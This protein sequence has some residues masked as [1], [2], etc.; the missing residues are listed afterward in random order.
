MK[1]S[2]RWITPKA[3]EEVAYMA[4]VSN[5]KAK[6]GDPAQKLIQFLLDNKHFSPFEMVCMCLDIETTRDVSRQMLRHDFRFQEFSQRYQVASEEPEMVPQARL[7]DEK[8]RQNSIPTTD[9][10]ITKRWMAIQNATWDF[11]WASYMV[12]LKLGI[13]KELARKLLPEG[14][15]RTHLYMQGTI[16]NWIFYIA[17]R[18]KPDT[19][20]EHRDVAEE[21]RRVFKMECPDIYA[22]AV[23]AGLIEEH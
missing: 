6:P 18:T 23:K 2:L 7:Q 14:L 22:A 5:P 11:C 17:C 3:D 15:V 21:V 20:K 10:Y 4:R 9:P 8:N 1:V 12:A 19:Q 13:A 16:R